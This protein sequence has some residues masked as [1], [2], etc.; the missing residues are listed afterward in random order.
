[1]LGAGE[2]SV[3]ARVAVQRF[4]DGIDGGVFIEVVRDYLRG[5]EG[6]PLNA[7]PEMVFRRWGDAPADQP[8][9]LSAGTSGLSKRAAAQ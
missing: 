3:E 9:D 2:E 1:M 6:Q 7:G 8:L 4:V 5:C